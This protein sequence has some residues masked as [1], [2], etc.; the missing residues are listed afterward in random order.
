[1]NSSIM[2]P[3]LTSLS[4]E[5]LGIGENAI[6]VGVHAP[7]DESRVYFIFAHRTLW[8]HHAQLAHAFTRGDLSRLQWIS[9]LKV[10]IDDS[11][12]YIAVGGRGGMDSIFQEEHGEGISVGEMM[13][14]VTPGGQ[15]KPAFALSRP[16]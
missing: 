13:S 6:F 11:G 7:G 3:L 9:V 10:K 12:N 4:L 8:S 1:M 2:S 15:V 5:H 16:S 14:G